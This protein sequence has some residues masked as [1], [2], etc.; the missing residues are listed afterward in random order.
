MNLPSWGTL[1][2]D[3]LP[4]SESQSDNS[5]ATTLPDKAEIIKVRHFNNDNDQFMAAVRDALYIDF[6]IDYETLR[7]QSLLASVASLL[8]IS[9]RNNT[10]QVITYNF[11]DVLEIYLRY[12]G[13][14]TESVIEANCWAS[15]SQVCINHLHGYLPYSEEQSST[16]IVLD[17]QS[18]NSQTNS[19][20]DHKVLNIMRRRFCIFVGLSGDDPHFQS[21][22]TQAENP[23]PAII[24]DGLPYFG[25][26][27][28]LESNSDTPDKVLLWKNRKIYPKVVSTWDE[29][30][31]YLFSIC[32]H[33]SAT[34][35]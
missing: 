22:L 20:W 25:I 1:L 13:F 24:L 32:Q 3:I 11:D 23:H 7:K 4:L 10:A 21:L 6:A 30:P 31:S 17:A 18:F 35:E 14:D 26:T 34:P 29:V 9:S 28:L 33:V 12:H 19:L 27:F 8:M 16:N 15:R 2:D 5:T